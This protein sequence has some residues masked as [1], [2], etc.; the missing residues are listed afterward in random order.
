MEL[1][2]SAYIASAYDNLAIID[3]NLL[4]FDEAIKKHKLGI[5]IA[6]KIKN[7][8]GIIS[9][10]NNLG[11]TYKN[12]GNFQEALNQY[13]ISY[14]LMEQIK[15]L[16]S[17]WLS[18]TA[19][20]MGYAYTKLKEFKKAESML[21]IGCHYLQKVNDNMGVTDAYYNLF[22][23]NQAKGDYKNALDYHKKYVALKDSTFTIEKSKQISEL[24]AKYNV[25]KKDFEIATLNQQNEIKEG[26]IKKQR[27]IRNSFIGASILLV[28][29]I[30]VIY[31]RFR[32][33]MKSEEALTQA[34][35]DLQ[36]TQHQLIQQEK[37]ASLGSLTAGIAHE[38]KNPLNF[39][40]NFSQLSGELIEEFVESDDEEDKLDILKSLKSNLEKINHHGK[41][42]NSIV[43][44][45]LQ[46]AR[47]G[48][49]EKQMTDINQ[50]CNEFTDLSFQGMRAKVQDFNCVI[51]KNFDLTLPLVNAIPQDVSR[52]ILN[53]LNNAFYATNEKK[54]GYKLNK[55][56][57]DYAPKLT[58]STTQQDQY[59]II[60]IKD[61]GSGIPEHIKQKIFEPFF[62]TKPSGEG[63]GLGLSI[64][65][66]IVKAHG[67]NMQ[68]ESQ[69]DSFTEF[70]ITLP[71]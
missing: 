7:S 9:G 62:T 23:L 64:C 61:N 70:I 66:D 45:M 6:E 14:K 27:V 5:Q 60:K 8:N 38:I 50:I 3:E 43:M 56:T 44:S 49:G 32:I 52:V 31:N 12:S 4:R 11:L 15:P 65:N 13:N 34:H 58:I 24:Q 33:K 21:L 26:V 46:H 67:G 48:E 53:L 51:E 22:E 2:D 20:N 63:T 55:S 30:L 47:G 41:R 39:V 29:L 36:A 54:M 57:T 17:L 37:L 18:Y 69:T 10:H 28:L 40:T 19:L 71:I 16:D 35:Q 1:K 42:A 68:V 25:E 59:V